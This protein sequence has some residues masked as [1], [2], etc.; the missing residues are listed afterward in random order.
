[1]IVSSL[2]RFFNGLMI[3]RLS[4]FSVP[5]VLVA[6]AAA[7]GV[8]AQLLLSLETGGNLVLWV[9]FLCLGVSDGLFWSSLPIVS[10]RMPN[11]L[12]CQLYRSSRPSHC[13]S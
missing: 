2:T 7:V 11:F 12:S 13:I 10:N 8:T 5:M 1:M 6:V 3:S 4:S 9:G